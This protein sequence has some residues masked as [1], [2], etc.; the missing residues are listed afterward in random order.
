MYNAKDGSATR[1]NFCDLAASDQVSLQEEIDARHLVD[2]KKIDL[3]V[4]TLEKVV[5]TVYASQAT[6]QHQPLPYRESKLTR[7]L[8]DSLT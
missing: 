2:L 1:F 7:I 8:G 4:K 5:K 6:A 3:S